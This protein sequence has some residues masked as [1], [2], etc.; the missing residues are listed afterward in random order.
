M[1]SKILKI[2]I[3]MFI[4]ALCLEIL[5][6]SYFDWIAIILILFLLLII[7]LVSKAWKISTI[8]SLCMGLSGI[9]ASENGGLAGAAILF[10]AIPFIVVPVAAWTFY[11]IKLLAQKGKD[12]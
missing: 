1:G 8:L 5:S 10:C 12:K 9:I 3:A 11:I 2:I 4:V 6:K 7:A